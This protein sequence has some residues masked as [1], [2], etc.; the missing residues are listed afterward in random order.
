MTPADKCRTFRELHATGCFVIPPW[1]V[2]TAR[3]LEGLGFKRWR[4]PVRATRIRKAFPTAPTLRRGAGAFPRHRQCYRPA[5][6]ADFENGYANDPLQ[7]AENVARCVATGVAGLSDR[8]RDRRG[9]E[10]LYD[11]TPRWRG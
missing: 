8:G 3:T 4:P 11:S 7:L 5:V 6:N 10:P 9:R 1:N 2:G